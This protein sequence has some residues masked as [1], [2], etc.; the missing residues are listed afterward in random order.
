MRRTA[1]PEEFRVLEVD[2]RRPCGP[3][4]QREILVILWNFSLASA[5]VRVLDMVRELYA[6]RP[7][8]SLQHKQE[9]RV[10]QALRT[11]NKLP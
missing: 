1:L 3:L 7:R 5:S 11:S 2:W 4:F 8:I 10:S 9:L 6:S